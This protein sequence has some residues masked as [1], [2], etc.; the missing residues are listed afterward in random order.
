MYIS[1]M[2]LQAYVINEDENH[3][4]GSVQFSFSFLSRELSSAVNNWQHRSPNGYK[5]T[6]I[7]AA[8]NKLA[9][10]DKNKPKLVASG[11]LSSYVSLLC[12]EGST[13]EEFRAR[14]QF[15]SAQGLWT[16]AMDCQDDVCKQDSCVTGLCG[17]YVFEIVD[18]CLGR[19]HSV[20]GIGP[21][22]GDHSLC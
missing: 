12:G 18:H 16:L 15:L 2:I 6:E 19:C 3:L 14:E 11:I 4:L 7:L 13:E 10:N 1:V 5:T 22:I 9:I 8:V 20:Y 21:A 17:S